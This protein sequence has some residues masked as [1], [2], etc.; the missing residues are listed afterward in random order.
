MNIARPGDLV[1][2]RTLR[3]GKV[4]SFLFKSFSLESLFS[5][6]GSVNGHRLF[7]VSSNY[8]DF[9]NAHKCSMQ[10]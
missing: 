10:S 2:C 4:P 3:K 1:F 6:N 7:Y 8:Y 5:N 9:K